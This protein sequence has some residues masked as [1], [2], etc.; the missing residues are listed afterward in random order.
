MV[1]HGNGKH[2]SKFYHRFLE[3][4]MKSFIIYQRRNFDLSRSQENNFQKI[5]KLKTLKMTFFC[6]NLDNRGGDKNFLKK[7]T[8][9]VIIIDKVNQSSVNF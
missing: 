9:L 3:I 6:P 5:E 1:Y 8:I 2:F 7:Q 4:S